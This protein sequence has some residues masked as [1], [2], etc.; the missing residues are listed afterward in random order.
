LALPSLPV[1]ASCSSASDSIV[2]KPFDRESS[3]TEPFG[4]IF[5]AIRARL[6]YVN[7]K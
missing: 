6:R 2:T 7:E 4:S 5:V 3:L 1:A